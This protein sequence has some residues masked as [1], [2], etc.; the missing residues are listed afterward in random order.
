MNWFEGFFD[1][2]VNEHVQCWG[3]GLF[4][5][6]FSVVS[7]A[8][9]VAYDK[10]IFFCT[11]LFGV[12]L[13]FYVLNAVWTNIKKGSDDSWYTKSVQ[14]ILINSVVALGLLNI[15]VALPR[16]ITTIT[17]EPV[18]EVALAYT[19]VMLKVTPEQT[20]QQV[21][22]TPMTIADNGF[23]RPQLRD[24]I[25]L[26]MK[27]TVSQFQ[28]YI[29]LGVAIMEEAFDWESMLTDGEGFLTGISNFIKHIIVFFIGLVLV[30]Q[31]FKLF[32]RFCCR[33]VDIIIAMTMFAFF[34]PISL[35]LTAFK[36]VE[37]VPS[38]ISALGKS[39]G[40]EQFKSL[41]N[42]I[43]SLVATLIT[44]TVIIVLIAKFFS[45]GGVSVTELM[46]AITSGEIFMM[47]MSMDGI[48]ATT[49]GGVMILLYIT[50]WIYQ[51]I[52][53]ITQMILSA[54]NVKDE[55]KIGESLADD[56]EK[57]AM[58]A[59][60]KTKKAGKAIIDVIKGESSK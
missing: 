54:F 16:F 58:G 36:D 30:W 32:F 1:S 27:T 53:Q 44:Y 38:W 35:V 25:I 14:K 46:A 5:R 8:A 52:G 15:G 59:L 13:A 51:Q 60:D 39:L 3:C 7:Q 56:T 40:I 50:N 41:V 55:S 2:A 47:D 9:A 21:T 10:L 20:Q 4:D 49:F 17:F 24:T 22:Y 28:S 34:F 29:K 37:G 42:S 6:L 33:F 43:I 18:A 11:L 48:Y 12:L 19:D 57:I 31:F 23:Y 26:M 45:D